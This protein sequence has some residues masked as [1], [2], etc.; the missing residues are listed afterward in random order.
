MSIF[1][2][3]LFVVFLTHYIYQRIFLPTL[4]TKYKYSLFALRDEL[5]VLRKENRKEEF[6]FAYDYLQSTINMSLNKVEN[7]DLLFLFKARK[8]Y[9]ENKKLRQ[10]IEE[11]YNKFKLCDDH[12]IH[13][14]HN[15]VNSALES[16]F[17]CNTGG[18]LLYGITILT[19]IFF[20]GKMKEWIN[21]IQFIP[22]SDMTEIASS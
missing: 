9:K 21:T 1:L 22:E 14:I 11:R 4:Q 12:R 8:S 2:A 7:F 16:L 10:I 5:R 13:D 3:V 6:I 18:F 15:R 17:L 20:I 19:L